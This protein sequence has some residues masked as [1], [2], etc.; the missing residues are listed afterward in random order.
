[1]TATTKFQNRF[2]NQTKTIRKKPFQAWVWTVRA[3]NRQETL[4]T[5]NSFRD[6]IPRSDWLTWGELSLGA[7]P[8][9][10]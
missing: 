1:M 7:Y 2:L 4:D 6:G 3:E 10:V 8:S 5:K 9:G